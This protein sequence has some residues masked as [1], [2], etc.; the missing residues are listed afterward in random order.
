MPTSF[1]RFRIQTLAVGAA[2]LAATA[3]L[4]DSASAVGLHANSKE[5][6]TGVTRS[7]Q[8]NGTTAPGAPTKSFAN[9]R[10]AENDTVVVEIS[11][12]DAVPNA[13]YVWLLVQT[14]PTSPCGGGPRVAVRTN[15]QGNANLRLSAPRAPGRTGAFVYSVESPGATILVS[16]TQT[17]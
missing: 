13:D 14:A 7:I 6:I 15:V 12:Q 16:S 8:C 2:V 5:S 4:A 9:I 17:F 1:A 10:L 11:M 3:L